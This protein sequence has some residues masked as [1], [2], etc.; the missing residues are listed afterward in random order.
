MPSENR[1][2][3]RTLPP[4]LVPAKFNPKGS[5]KKVLTRG[6]SQ[7]SFITVCLRLDQYIR[8][9]IKR[10]NSRFRDSHFFFYKFG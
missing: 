6:Y 1:D 2:D 5:H 7:D 10:L 3:L 8:A 4:N 9:F